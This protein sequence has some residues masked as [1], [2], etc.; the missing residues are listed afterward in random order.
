[1]ALAVFSSFLSRESESAV[2]NLVRIPRWQVKCK[3][4][5]GY[6]LVATHEVYTDWT[7]AA[8]GIWQAMAEAGDKVPPYRQDGRL[9]LQHVFPTI[10]PRYSAHVRLPEFVRCNRYGTLWLSIQ[11]LA[12][13]IAVLRAHYPGNKIL[14][15]GLNGEQI[16]T[17]EK[18]LL[19]NHNLGANT[20]VVNVIPGSN[21]DEV[22]LTLYTILL[23]CA[24][25]EFEREDPHKHG[26]DPNYRYLCLIDQKA[27]LTARDDFLR[28][29]RLGRHNCG[30]TIRESLIE[31]FTTPLLTSADSRSSKRVAKKR[32]AGTYSRPPWPRAYSASSYQ[33]VR[34]QSL[35]KPC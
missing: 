5:G 26:L 13:A 14:C 18:H 32:I 27:P 11:G 28:R 25:L 2:S 19:A 34:C 4:G 20:G 35:Q 15:T 1:M 3:K 6:S 7:V 30:S 10:P 12:S 23:E 33:F 21:T 17:L 31:T 29:A 22:D 16:E 8:D 24:G 9:V